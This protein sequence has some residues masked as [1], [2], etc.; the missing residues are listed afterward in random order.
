M[1]NEKDV[2]TAEDTDVTDID[3]SAE[4]EEEL[5]WGLD[6]EEPEDSEEAEDSEDGGEG[7][8][9]DEEADDGGEESEDE[10][11][12]EAEGVDEPTQPEAGED[13]AAE[14][15]RLKREAQSTEDLVRAVLT[16]LGADT[17]DIKAG[18]AAL[19]GEAKGKTAE[20]FIAE[21]NEA[22]EIEKLKAESRERQAKAIREAD[23]AQIKAAYPTVDLDDITKIDNYKRFG[24]LRMAG[25]TA[26]EAYAA[27]NPTAIKLT[28]VES[29]K[30]QASATKGTKDHLRSKATRRS[31]TATSLSD[32][33]MREWRDLFPG[34]SDEELNK[35][36][37]RAS[38][39]MKGA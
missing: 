1:D 13:L 35:L 12:E 34:K 31:G 33:E 32:G 24:E 8:D 20:Q 25:L 2:T 21:H 7:T 5:D 27:T 19:A 29:G 23:L 11:E 9:E 3:V 10:T 28:G 17:K 4:E 14:N 16:A 37:R 36:A 38:E 18:L 39:K 30:R 26:A 6:D 15:E 22:R